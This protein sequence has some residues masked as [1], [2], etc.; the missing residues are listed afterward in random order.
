MSAHDRAPSPVIAL[1]RAVAIGLAHGP[2]P[3]SPRS[4]R[5]MPR[6]C[7]RITCSPRL[8]RISYAGSTAGPS[9]R[10]Y[11]RAL[12]LADNGPERTFLAARLAACEKESPA[13]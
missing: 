3:G 12:D 4:T 7:A 9:R 8:A 13:P 6:P 11:R 2:A 10:R 1:N 5:S